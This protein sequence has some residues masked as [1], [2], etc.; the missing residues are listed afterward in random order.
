MP[1]TDLRAIPDQDTTGTTVRFLP[2]DAVRSMAEVS[3]S[4]LR[5]LTAAWPQL[6]VEV[7]D[8]RTV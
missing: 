5:R 7:I 6:A 4:V 3:P 2:A 8:E 1:V